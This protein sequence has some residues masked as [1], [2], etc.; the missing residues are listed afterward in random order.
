[1]ALILAFEIMFIMAWIELNFIIV[2][3]FFCS[4]GSFI[5]PA[6][7]SP[8]GAK[9][10]GQRLEGARCGPAGLRCANPAGVTALKNSPYGRNGPSGR[11]MPA[12]KK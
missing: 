9:K 7:F 10:F 4:I 1:M 2:R 12:T 3:F 6:R 11:A 5:N 8:G